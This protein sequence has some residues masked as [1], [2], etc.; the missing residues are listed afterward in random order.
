MIER[1]VRDQRRERGEAEQQQ[2]AEPGLHA[3]QHHRPPISCTAITSGPQQRGLRQ[4]ERLKLGD[5]VGAMDQLVDA[6][7]QIDRAQA[8]A[9]PQE[10]QGPRDRSFLAYAF[11]G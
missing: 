9:R 7:E 11:G 10:I 6:A 2:R 3:E 1:P 5:R 8:D 4:L